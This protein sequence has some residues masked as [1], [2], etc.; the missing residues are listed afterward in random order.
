MLPG[1]AASAAPGNNSSALLQTYHIGNSETWKSFN[2]PFGCFW[3]TLK[4]ENVCSCVCTTS[5]FFPLAVFHGIF[6]TTRYVWFSAGD[7]EVGGKSLLSRL[8]HPWVELH[9]EGASGNNEVYAQTLGP[10]M[11]KGAGEYTHSRST[12]GDRSL[13]L[14]SRAVCVTKDYDWCT[15]SEGSGMCSLPC[16][17]TAASEANRSVLGQNEVRTIKTNWADSQ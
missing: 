6:L 7:L 13:S 8:L 17:K 5:L 12:T 4:F 2:K 9:R 14:M 1:P 16:T 10:D 3:C 11:E 15:H